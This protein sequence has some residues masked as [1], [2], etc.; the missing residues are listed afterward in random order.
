MF[1]WLYDLPNWG[2]F[3]LFVA[4]A[5]A[6]CWSAV[7]LL[8]PAMDR[9]FGGEDREQR[10]SLLDLVLSGTGLFYGL[11]LG[12]IAAATYTTY[13]EAEASVANEATAV[14]AL[15]RDVSGYPEPFRSQ[16]RA[17][18]EFYVDNLVKVSWPKQ[19]QGEI[20]TEGTDQ[21]DVIQ[22]RMTTFE[23]TTPGQEVL[24]AEAYSQFNSFVEARRKVLNS[25]SASLPGALWW[26]LVGGALI[27]LLLT[28]MLA[29]ERLAPHLVISGLFA[30]FIAMMI[31]LIAAMDNP[32]LG[33]F[34]V[35][36]QP[37]ERLQQNLFGK[38]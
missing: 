36:P 13:S 9:L 38:A 33:E 25:V 16:L 26:V 23:P 11:L 6:I 5:L 29:V 1:S 21:V 7:I 32:F 18:I 17:D 2:M 22:R 8:R 34:S 19:Q 15:Y 4:V 12:L 27:N 30:V 10:N 20:P 37:F 24:H 35:P 31:F 3:L 14:A 28:S